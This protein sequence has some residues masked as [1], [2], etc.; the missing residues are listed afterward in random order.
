MNSPTKPPA[1]EQSRSVWT[2]RDETALR[3]LLDRRQR[4]MA[5]NRRR[6]EEVLSATSVP[7]SPAEI[8]SLIELA[9]PLRDALK[10]FDGRETK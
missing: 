9:E 3:E 6:L 8:D 7:L 2:Q 10:P 4:I 5:D 1:A